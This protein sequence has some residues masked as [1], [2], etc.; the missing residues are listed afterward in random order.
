LV[1]A[2]ILGG[3]GT[4]ETE[5]IATPYIYDATYL[6]TF[7]MGSEKKVLI[8][9]SMVR[10]LIAKDYKKVAEYLSEDIVFNLSDGSSIEGK[11]SAIKHISDTYSGV[12]IKDYNVAV[13]LAVTGDNGDEW[14]LLWDN[15]KV[16]NDNGDVIAQ[17]SWME[18]FRFEGD[19]ISFINQY[20]KSRN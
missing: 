6:D 16:V 1:I 4:H 7:E 18:S 19:K 14:V 20:S 17:Q 12:N 5:D 9:Q 8:V 11:E 10:D 3:H 13:N 2:P 15:G